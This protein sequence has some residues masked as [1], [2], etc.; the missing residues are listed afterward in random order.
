MSD[1]QVDFTTYTWPGDEFGWVSDTD[2]FTES[3]FYVPMTTV[4]RRY[5]L[6]DETTVT[7]H[8][9]GMLC[10]RC[11]GEGEVLQSWEALTACPRCKF[12]S[13]PMNLQGITLPPAAKP[14][15]FLVRLAV[16]Q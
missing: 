4:R 9:R 10:T 8:P 16:H 15:M 7:W 11:Q 6:L 2:M 14:G 1:E 13:N 5:R 12:T 3:D